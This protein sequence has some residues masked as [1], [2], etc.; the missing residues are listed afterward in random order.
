[1]SARTPDVGR[2]GT[3]RRVA[4]GIEA[5]SRPGIFGRSWWSRE[6]I[7]AMEQVADKGRL[8]R[9]RSCARGG[10]VISLQVAPG[11]VT[12]EVQGS[13]LRPFTATVSIRTLDDGALAELVAQVRAV[14]GTL[15]ALVSGA[16]P[17]ALGPLLLP[18]KAGEL[19]F[20]CTC[21]D[22]GWPCT[23]AAAAAYLTAEH[24]DH[25]PLAVLTLRGVEL[26]AVIRGVAGDGAAWDGVSGDEPHVDPADFFGD[27]T[28]LP[29]LPTEE[30]RPALDD[31]DSTLLRAVLRAGA[32][33]E[34]TVRAG[35]R[36]LED[37]YRNVR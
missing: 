12:A 4:A 35:V 21:P 19:D 2:Y 26:D 33:D 24:I 7:A 30:F 28:T 1:M 23:H 11:L 8:S 37:C 17:E 22:G 34:A 36:D 20:D 32:V 6:L 3:R 16:V 13:Q 5:H 31:L 14:P 15:A 29:A 27:R 25:D 10:Q 9:G 18:R